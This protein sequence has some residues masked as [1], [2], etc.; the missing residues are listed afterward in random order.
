MVT[1]AGSLCPLP[2]LALYVALG[3]LIPVALI[4]AAAE[5]LTRPPKK[6]EN[7]SWRILF[8]SFLFKI[9]MA[10]SRISHLAFIQPHASIMETASPLRIS[11]PSCRKKLNL[12]APSL[13]KLLPNPTLPI[14]PWVLRLKYSARQESRGLSLKSGVMQSRNFAHFWFY[15][16]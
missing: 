7:G 1:K 14:G 15:P 16:N 8:S 9:R 3:A 2:R 12:F 13:L 11:I 4:R 6:T 5:R 10:S